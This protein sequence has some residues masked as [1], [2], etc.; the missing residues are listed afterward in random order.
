MKNK[1]V[2]SVLVHFN[3][4]TVALYDSGKFSVAEKS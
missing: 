2:S 1:V 3:S 4:Q